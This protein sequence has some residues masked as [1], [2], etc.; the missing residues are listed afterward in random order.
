MVYL[1]ALLLC[2]ALF[3]LNFFTSNLSTSYFC[4][5]PYIS[6]ENAVSKATSDF[7][8]AT[9]SCHSCLINFLALKSALK[10]IGQEF[11]TKIL[12]MYSSGFPPSSLRVVLFSCSSLLL[13]AHHFSLYILTL[14]NPL[15][16]RES[17]FT[18]VLPISI[19]DP[20]LPREL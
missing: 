19:C 9:S 8:L 15:L 14:A 6:T 18:S 1:C 20:E 13:F 10:I 16:G 17:D 5:W 3:F 4:F 7:L 12:M 11:L 2:S